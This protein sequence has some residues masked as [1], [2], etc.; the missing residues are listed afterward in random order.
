MH[1]WLGRCADR[2][3][4]AAVGEEQTAVSAVPE[5]HKAC[6]P[7]GDPAIPAAPAASLP[8]VAKPAAWRSSSPARRRMAGGGPGAA[9]DGGS[10]CAGRQAPRR[11][12]C[13]LVPFPIDCGKL[14]TGAPSRW[15]RIAGRHAAVLTTQRTEAL[16]AVHSAVWIYFDRFQKGGSANEASAVSQARTCLLAEHVFRYRHLCKYS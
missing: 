12:L 16:G 15:V 11:K 5:Q 7:P 13:R 14:W 4:Q 1:A 10:C 8:P 3:Q 6:S 9:A 2:H